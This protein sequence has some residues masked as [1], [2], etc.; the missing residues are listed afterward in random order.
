MN[1]DTGE[2]RELAPGEPLKPKEVE[3]TAA[4]AARLG[5]LALADRMADLERQRGAPITGK[6]ARKLAKRMRRWW[7]R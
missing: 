7:R 6:R 2:I 4:E 3:I 5:R 1:T